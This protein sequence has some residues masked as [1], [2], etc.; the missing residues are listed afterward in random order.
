MDAPSQDVVVRFF[1]SMK[2]VFE[3]KEAR[4]SRGE[5][6]DVGTLLKRVCTKPEMERAIFADSS[7]LRPALIVLLNGRNIAFLGGLE[8]VVREGDEVAIFPPLKGG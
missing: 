2:D 8:A 5:A 4:V 6:P 7:T 1:A 3:R